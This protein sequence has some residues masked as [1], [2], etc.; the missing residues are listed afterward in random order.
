MGVREPRL[1]LVAGQPGHQHQRVEEDL[2]AA[3]RRCSVV[4]STHRRRPVVDRRGREELPEASGE[5]EQEER[6]HELEN[7]RH[8]VAGGRLCLSVGKVTLALSA[9]QCTP[10]GH[11]RTPLFIWPH[12]RADERSRLP[13]SATFPSARIYYG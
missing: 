2:A 7:P 5:Q 12:A 10:V 9:V 4:G 3:G 13:Q 8:D 11:V 6:R 1:Q